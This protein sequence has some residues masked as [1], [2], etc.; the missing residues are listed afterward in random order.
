MPAI[1]HGSTYG[2]LYG[3]ESATREEPLKLKF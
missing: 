3:V 1:V 2:V